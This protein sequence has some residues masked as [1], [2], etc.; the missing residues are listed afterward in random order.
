MV[1]TLRTDVEQLVDFTHSSSTLKTP[2]AQLLASLILQL[3]SVAH[4]LT[5]ESVDGSMQC[6]TRFFFCRS[7]FPV[8]PTHQ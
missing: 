3:V 2:A 1:R 4:T 8:G 7:G 6:V 5:G